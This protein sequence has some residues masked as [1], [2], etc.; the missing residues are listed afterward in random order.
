M[1]RPA[2]PADLPELERIETISFSS[3][4]ISHRSFRRMLTR[5]HATLL[6]EDPGDGGPRG[7]ALVLYNRATALGRLYSIAVAPEHRGRGVARA[8]L[9]AAEA[10]ALANNCVALR[11]E[12][13]VD[14]QASLSLFRRAGYRS[15]VEVPD[16]YEDHAAALRFEKDLAPRP[17]PSR[18]VVPYYEQ[19]LP[20]TCGPASLMMAMKALDGDEPLTR[21]LELRLWRESTTIFMTSGLGGCGP[22]GMALSAHR[23]G[24]RVEVF[25]RDPEVF[26]VDSVRSPD[27]KEVM[28]LVQED[29]Q[30]ELSRAGVPVVYRALTLDEVEYRFARGGIPLVLI[31]NYRIYQ[32][33][34]PHWVVATGIDRSFI[35]VHDP[36]IDR[37]E[38]ETEGDSMS[39]P[40]ARK[41]FDRMARY[42]R[43]GQRACLVLYRRE[44]A[45]PAP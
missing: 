7:Y 34:A 10:D 12:I 16:Y 33:R 41:E 13:R 8:L 23:R 39:L 36:F 3:E 11:L 44:A 29:F 22:Y 19:T 30:E 2:V 25:V 31:S 4:R 26:L 5:A 35:Y 32:E 27:K 24:F 17:D 14:N 37:A 28:R 20:F 18:V 42:G 45:S 38:G 6:V 43:S 1:I 40:I 9:A 15:F 21:A